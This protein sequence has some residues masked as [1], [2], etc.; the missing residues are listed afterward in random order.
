MVFT[1]W[2][3]YIHCVIRGH[4]IPIWNFQSKRNSFLVFLS[5]EVWYS[6]CF[7]KM[8]VCSWTF[9]H[10]KKISSTFSLLS[11]FFVLMLLSSLYSKNQAFDSNWRKITTCY[12]SSHQFFSWRQTMQSPV[13]ERSSSHL[14]LLIYLRLWERRSWSHLFLSWYRQ[15]ILAPYSHLALERC[16][17]QKVQLIAL[18]WF[19]LWHPWFFWSPQSRLCFNYWRIMFL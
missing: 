7:S 16:L 17:F 8:N 14:L 12:R 3:L 13:K 2:I 15:Y 19:L 5:F 9:Q 18:P 4:F 1:I 10:I 6:F 11:S